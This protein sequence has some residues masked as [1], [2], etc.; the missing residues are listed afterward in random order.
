M[1]TYKCITLK[2]K[3]NLLIFQGFLLISFI[4]NAVSGALIA[5]KV[6]HYRNTPR[7]IKI[8]YSILIDKDRCA[9]YNCTLLETFSVRI[10]V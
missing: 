8:G 2:S 6:W 10:D 4:A 5:E 3:I 1:I 9:G 7:E